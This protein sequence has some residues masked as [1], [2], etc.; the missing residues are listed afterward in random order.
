VITD[1]AVL[2]LV[3]GVAAD[4]LVCALGGELP[5]VGVAA[6]DEALAVDPPDAVVV[7]AAAADAALFARA[8]AWADRRVLRPG[9]IAWIAGAAD[10]VEVALAAGFDDAVPDTT[11]A[12]ELAAR[13]RVVDRRVRRAARVPARLYY[14]ALVLAAADQIVWVDGAP[15]PLSRQELAVLR[16]LIVAGGVAMTRDALLDA[17]WGARRV[18]VGPRAVDNVIVNL[19]RKLGAPARI[20]TVRGVG[21]RLTR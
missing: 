10:G 15:Q 12:R 21:F 11:S 4:A 3:G 5:R 13:V 16:A 14:G 17:A 9:L 1:P 7:L 20:R 6:L 19:R 2:V 8:I 18:G